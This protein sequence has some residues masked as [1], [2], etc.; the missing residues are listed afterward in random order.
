MSTGQST[1]SI[2][3]DGATVDVTVLADGLG[4][5]AADIHLL[6]RQGKLTSKFEKGVGDDAGRCRLTFWMGAKRFRILV[7]AQGTVLKRFHTDYGA[8]GRR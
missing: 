1:I 3:N 6:I 5:E 4:V 7:D 8:L 2:N